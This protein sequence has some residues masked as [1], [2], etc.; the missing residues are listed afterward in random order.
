MELLEGLPLQTEQFMVQVDRV[1]IVVVLPE[2]SVGMEEM[3]GLSQ[4][5]GEPI[6]GEEAKVVIQMGA[7]ETDL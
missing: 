4:N 3:V 1:Q 6:L 2:M 5:W 7:V